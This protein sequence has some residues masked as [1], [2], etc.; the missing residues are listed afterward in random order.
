MSVAAGGTTV[1]A[2]DSLA[3]AR[4]D[5]MNRAQPGYR[6]DSILPIEEAL[7]R[8]RTALPGPAPTALSGGAPGRDAL[9]RSFVRALEAADTAGLEALALTPAE[10]GWLVYP[11]SPYMEAPYR[12][13]P[14]LVWMQIALAGESGR[15]RLLQRLEGRPLGFAGYSCDSEPERQGENRLWRRCQVRLTQPTGASRTLRLFGD[16]IERRGTF[17]FV[18]FANDL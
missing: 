9:V 2:L 1:D 16:I 6:I 14:A 3:R 15:A 18:S 4:Q 13:A 5:S 11:S 7:R 10:F 12:Q 17:K 8:F